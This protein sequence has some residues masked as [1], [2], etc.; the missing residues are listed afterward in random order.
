MKVW[1]D[2]LR[3]APE[4]FIHVHNLDE[5]IRLLTDKDE[6]IEVMSFDHDLGQDESGREELSGYDIIK[7]LA[8]NYLDRWPTVV[9]VHSANPV[10]A[11][12]IRCFDEFVRKRLL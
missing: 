11:E 3:P 12:N 1:L 4:G 2:D 6:R 8:E 7:W 5:F 10:G 9:R